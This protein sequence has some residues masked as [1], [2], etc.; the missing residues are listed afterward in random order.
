MTICELR[1]WCVALGTSGVLLGSVPGA[2]LVESTAYASEPAA[3]PRVPFDEGRELVRQGRYGEARRKF[4]ESLAIRQTP[5]ALL[6]IG[7]CEEKLGRYASAA[8]A[9]QRARALAEELAQAERV[10]EAASRE[11]RL[12]PL[13][14][15]LTVH[16][17]GLASSRIT[18][19]GVDEHADTALPVDGGEHVVRVTGPCQLFE[20]TVEV[21]I[22]RDTQ[23]VEVTAEGMS[24]DPRCAREVGPVVRV[25][26][27]PEVRPGPWRTLAMVGAGAGLV[28]LGVGAGFGIDAM[29]KKDDLDGRCTAYPLGCPLAQQPV[30]DEL[31]SDARR[32]AAFSTVGLVAGGALL[33]GA[34]V[35]Y[36]LSGPTPPPRVSVR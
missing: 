10:E 32:S 5:G 6:N 20:T 30:I 27:P 14:S 25:A 4:E 23:R 8:A 19:D 31:A 11:D 12:R 18:V 13:I 24:P 29:N 28:A 7:D 9:F 35:T 22:T 3:D 15:T 2:S 17:V 1:R 16:V 34:V 33:V 21:A 36:L 26:S